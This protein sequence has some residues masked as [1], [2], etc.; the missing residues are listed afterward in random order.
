ML[1][2][3]QIN[4]YNINILMGIFNLVSKVIKTKIDLIKQIADLSNEK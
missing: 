3:L 4:N 1:L 2:K